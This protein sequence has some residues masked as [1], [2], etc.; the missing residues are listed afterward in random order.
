[1]ISPRAHSR[2][3]RSACAAASITLRM[4]WLVR[5]SAALSTVCC[6]CDDSR[7]KAEKRGKLMARSSHAAATHRT[8]RLRRSRPSSMAVSPKWSPGRSVATTRSRCSLSSLAAGSTGA[9]TAGAS[10]GAAAAPG[11]LAG[12]PPCPL[13]ARAAARA[14]ALAAFQPSFS[15]AAAEA[16]AMDGPAPC[17]SSCGSYSQSRRPDVTK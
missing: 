3:V 10:S 6:S 17:R 8:V 1:M 14:L 4:R 2:S 15:T 7:K 9:L 5:I 13:A 11:P 16:A 12:A